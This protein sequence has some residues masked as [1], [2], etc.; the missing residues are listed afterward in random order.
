MK[1]GALYHHTVS[2][3]F[4][5]FTNRYFSFSSFLLLFLFSSSSFSPSIY[6]Y[7][8]PP[9]SVSPS[10][11][12]Y[13]RSSESILQILRM[14][15]RGMVPRTSGNTVHD[16]GSS[17]ITGVENNKIYNSC[18]TVA[19]KEEKRKLPAAIDNNTSS[20]KSEVIDLV[21]D[22]DEGKD[23]VGRKVKNRTSDAASQ[24]N[25]SHDLVNSFNSLPG[26]I[27]PVSPNKKKFHL[28]YNVAL[29]RLLIKTVSSPKRTIQKKK[30]MTE[31][32]DDDDD[33]DEE[34]E[35]EEEEDDA[36]ADD[37]DDDES[38]AE[39]KEEEEKKKGKK[40]KKRVDAPGT[41]NVN[42]DSLYWYA[43]V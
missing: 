1:N 43:Y 5:A 31:K 17:P 27:S 22:S 9:H 7:F 2:L 11:C 13:I 28:P 40:S 10:L 26:Q 24:S 37:D 8:S 29:L 39:D 14:L 42:V 18:S 34:E 6:F 35:E 21:S 38:D 19:I 4:S 36:A 20:K 23:A 41:I 15:L 33:D 3:S 12:Y 30:I 32:D 25:A 16:K